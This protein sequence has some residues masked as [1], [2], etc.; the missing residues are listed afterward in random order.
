[1][2]DLTFLDR[3]LDA[4]RTLARAK[5]P[6]DESAHDF[7]HVL[8]VAANAETLARAEGASVGVAVSAALL[9]ELF[10]HPKGHPDKKRSGE[11]CAA[12]AAVELR[13]L[14]A[15]EDEVAAV[16]YAI[17]VH[18][19]SLGVLPTTL[20]ARILQDADRLDA[21]GAVGIARCFATTA[22]MKRPF[23]SVDDP[24]C[25]SRA[26]DDRAW[27]IDHFFTKLLGLG[28]GMHTATARSIAAR[29]VAFMRTFLDELASEITP[30]RV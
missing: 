26:P 9:H 21:I 12:R 13:A 2:T 25:S 8:R 16:S 27:G 10:N 24:F 15:P 23:Y 5:T 18:P 28:A 1:M 3:N 4:V 17:A 20:E 19:F 22:D 30:A 14:G 6:G 29:R 11:I 7:Q